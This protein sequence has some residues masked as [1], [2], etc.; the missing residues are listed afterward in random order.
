MLGVV[1]DVTD[2]RRAQ[3]GLRLERDTAQRYLDIAGVVLVALNERGE[4][5]LINRKGCEILG[6]EEQEIL[7]ANWFE[8]FLPDSIRSD[9]AE[10]FRLLMSD[11]I[12]IAQRHENPILCRDGETRVLKWS[13][14]VLRDAQGRI[15]GTLSSGTDITER[16]RAEESLRR[17]E[18]LLNQTF[19]AIPD[20]IT[21]MNREFDIVFSNWQGQEYSSKRM[22]ATRP[23]CHRA[24]MNRDTPCEACPVLNVFETGHPART[25]KRTPV[26]GRL[27][28]ISAYPVFDDDEDVTL[29]ITHVRDITDRERLEDERR[30]LEEQLRHAQQME[31]IG[32]LAAG[33]AH[34]INN[35]L[36]AIIGHAEIAGV[37]LGKTHETARDIE[38]VIRAARQA[39][40]VT[41]SL[42]TF[43]RGTAT[44]LALLDSTE[45][46]R[47]SLEMLAHM[48]PASIDQT[49]DLQSSP[50]IWI[51]GDPVQLKQVIVNLVVNARDAM[52]G[53]GELRVKLH[54]E[55]PEPESPASRIVTGGHGVARLSVIDTGIGMSPETRSRIFDPFFTTKPR[56][57]GTG[58]GMSVVH[59]II[60]S[61]GGLITI[62][63]DLGEGTTITVFFPGCGAPHESPQSPAGS[64]AAPILEGLVLVAE[65]NPQVRSVIAEGLES[66]GY[67]V[68][69][70]RDG[71]EA[72]ERYLEHASEIRLLLLDQ[73]MPKASGRMCL[74]KIRELSPD[75]PAILMSGNHSAM[76]RDEDIAL[77][78]KPFAISE[79]LALAAR[80]Q[81]ES[82]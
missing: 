13:N 80:V 5:T 39:A 38:G 74:S 14:T 2:R 3:E 47:E 22:R 77:L 69:V 82:E 31:A 49:I 17:S 40:G 61:H 51:N 24:I 43:S 21:A 58:L 67:P 48:L 30:E 52:P 79:L 10:V 60:E 65:D 9:A 36:T 76:G 20:L 81:S 59:G 50:P 42:L 44:D 75:I 19:L 25:E 73:D 56:E 32:T 63:S 18:S 72:L 55:F 4:V 12:E 66:S 6:Y 26:D 45:L 53:G 27:L 71:E 15:H 28:E 16:R 64:S 34:D 1:M 11:Q 23:K 8:R 62:E 57:Q 41:R 37:S 7:G 78:S 54:S 68:V 70:A 33:V 35:A 46:V 29:V